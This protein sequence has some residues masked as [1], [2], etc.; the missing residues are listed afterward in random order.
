MPWTRLCFPTAVI[1]RAA[2]PLSVFS[3]THPHWRRAT[4]TAVH[5]GQTLKPLPYRAKLT[6]QIFD[7]SGQSGIQKWVPPFVCSSYF[8]Y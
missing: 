8:L 1:V 6:S 5:G 7:E 3:P 2:L 4:V